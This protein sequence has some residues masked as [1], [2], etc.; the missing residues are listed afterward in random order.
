LVGGRKR[1][2][3]GEQTKGLASALSMSALNYMR[4][5]IREK[6]ECAIKVRMV[7]LSKQLFAQP[8]AENQGMDGGVG[9]GLV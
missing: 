3:Y 5:A 4:E 6:N 9:E 1:K 7:V 8:L 2:V